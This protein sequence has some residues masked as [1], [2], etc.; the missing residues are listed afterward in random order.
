MTKAL[1]GQTRRIAR[2]VALLAALGGAACDEPG[3]DLSDD[4][5]WPEAD[6]NRAD[7]SQDGGTDAQDDPRS[8]ASNDLSVDGVADAR[9]DAADAGIDNSADAVSDAFLDAGTDASNDAKLGDG[10]TKFSHSFRRIRVSSEF[11]CEGSAYADFDGDGD[12]DV[13]FGPRWYEGPAFT[14]EH[15]LYPTQAFD[16]HQYADCF[17]LFGH[18]IDGDGRADILRVGFPGTDATWFRNPG[19]AGGAWAKY[20]VVDKVD[21]ESPD[22]TDI[23]GDGRPEL[24]FGSGG[25]VVYA[26]PDSADPTLPWV[27]HP[28]TPVA[29]FQTFTHGLGV[30]DVDGDGLRDLLEVTA[31]WKHPPS[32]AGDPPWERR[33]TAFGTVGGGQ[34]ITADFDGDG[35]A[36]VVANMEAHGYGLAWYEQTPT[37]FTEHV[38]VAPVPDAGGIWLH[39]PHSLAVADV[40]KDGD[41]DIITGERFWA[42]VPAGTPDFNAPAHLYWFETVRSGSSVSWVPHLIDNGSGVGTQVTVADVTGDGWVDVV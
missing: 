41:P 21:I 17:F 29:G 4:R 31:W 39:E 3:P 11:W 26:G 42:H 16:P 25:R 8:D 15:E 34:M 10:P 36:D 20:T 13:A 37:G 18:D 30:G 40:D 32:L 24:V 35:D 5:R 23:T 14:T 1:G 9:S 33:P 2:L 19:S 12:L 27:A 6:A 22:F 28:M 7:V 38:I